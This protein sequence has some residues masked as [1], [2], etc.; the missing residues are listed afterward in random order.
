MIILNFIL[1]ITNII[2]NLKYSKTQIKKLGSTI[3]KEFGQNKEISEDTLKILHEYRVSFKEP[4]TQIFDKVTEISRI[5]Q[6]GDVRTYRI[7]RIES[8]ISKLLREKTMGLLEMGDIAGCRIIVSNPKHIQKIVSLIKNKLNVVDTRDYISEPRESGYKSYHLMIKPDIDDN[9]KRLVEVQIRTIKHH[10]WATL[11]EI[12]DQLFKVKVKEGENNEILKKFHYLRSKS[13]SSLTIDEMKEII[14]IE[15]NHEI[16]K[17]IISVI[18]KN[19]IKIRSAWMRFEDENKHN[20]YILEV[21]DKFQTN[22]ETFSDFEKAQKSYLKKYINT[23]NNVVLTHIESINFKKL[24]TAYSNYI[25]TFHHYEEEI[26][27]ILHDLLLYYS[28]NKD[29]ELFNYYKTYTKQIVRNSR[30]Y[31]QYSLGKIKN[32][33]YSEE[34]TKEWIFEIKE[35]LDNMRM[36]MEVI[37]KIPEPKGIIHKI[38]H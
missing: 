17:K 6:K 25:L 23:T 26:F 3:R 31:F 22:I 7:K 9:F 33:N 2:N 34:K 32:T 15:K 16:Y 11:V 1:H 27:N 38:F 30:R 19:Y 20:Y 24:S 35:R 8:I 4:M 21:N 18:I 14:D 13:I 28:S 10:N 37:D 36:K 12:T 29:K 5:V